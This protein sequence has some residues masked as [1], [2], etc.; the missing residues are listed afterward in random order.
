MRIGVHWLFLVLLAVAMGAGY[1]AEA[2]ILVGSLVAHEIAH[3]AV[4]WVLGLPVE[5]VIITPFGGMARLDTLVESDPQAE[6]S[7]ALAGP[8]QSFFLAGLMLFLSGDQLFDQRLVKFCFEV[9]ANLA[10]FNLIPALPLDGGRA[11]RGLMAQR[12]GY[13]RVTGWM[14][15]LGRFCGVGMAV[16]ALLVWLRTESHTLFLT[17]LVG[18]IFVAVGAGQEVEGATYRSYRQFLR[19]RDQLKETRVLAARQLVAVAGTR[20]GELMEHLVLRRYHVVLV[21][22]RDLQPL[23]TLY[24][25]ELMEAFQAL[26]PETLVEEVLEA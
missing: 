18:G 8:F 1:V 5:E 7:I 9:N 19:K 16:A 13:R 11:L 25:A 17:P 15:M 10:F 26:G 24:E 12:W 20:L 3:L 21:V 4:A 6:T 23:G 22:D 14:A 2:L